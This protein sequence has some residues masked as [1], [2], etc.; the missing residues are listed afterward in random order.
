[1]L[2]TFPAAPHCHKIVLKLLRLYEKSTNLSYCSRQSLAKPMKY[3]IL[4]QAFPALLQP[5]S[6][7]DSGNGTHPNKYLCPLA[8]LLVEF[9]LLED[10]DALHY[11]NGKSLQ[12]QNI[13]SKASSFPE[14]LDQK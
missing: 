5:P 9:F 8:I 1:M 7:L 12:F 4:P 13:L 14:S 6:P 2:Q 10:A 11:P 3:A